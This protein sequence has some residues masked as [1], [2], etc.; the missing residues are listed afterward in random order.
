MEAAH[1]EKVRTLALCALDGE[2]RCGILSKSSF[3]LDREY[4]PFGRCKS[5]R[6]W[7]PRRDGRCSKS[8]MSSDRSPLSLPNEASNSLRRPTC[9]AG[10]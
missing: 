4:L 9:E 3:A 1:G 5:R 2:C 6:W 8:P 10:D 7:S